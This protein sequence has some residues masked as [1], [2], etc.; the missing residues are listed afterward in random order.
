[1]S[2]IQHSWPRANRAR[3][4]IFLMNADGTGETQLT[5]PPGVN[6]GA[7]WT[8]HTPPALQPD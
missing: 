2:L 7:D 1:M 4:S 6:L 5:G 3:S 8:A